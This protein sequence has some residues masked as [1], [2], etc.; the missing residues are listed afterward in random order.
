[1]HWKKSIIQQE[2][3]LCITVSRVILKK[4]YLKISL[5]DSQAF[6]WYVKVLI[7]EEYVSLNR[8]KKRSEIGNI[9]TEK[10]N[11]TEIWNGA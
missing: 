3:K 10:S 5:Q 1:M 8:N 7:R 6:F 2:L 4:K 9:N 11:G